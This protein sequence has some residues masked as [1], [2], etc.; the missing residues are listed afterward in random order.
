MRSAF[1]FGLAGLAVLLGM[2][3]PLARANAQTQGGDA[4]LLVLFG[5]LDSSSARSP[6]V[7]DRRSGGHRKSARGLVETQKTTT[8]GRRLSLD[9]VTARKPSGAGRHQ[10]VRRAPVREPGEGTK[11]RQIAT[12]AR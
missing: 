1:T 4:A 11:L 3:W 10:V 9:D 6:G 12:S 7:S 8:T 5:L 2:L